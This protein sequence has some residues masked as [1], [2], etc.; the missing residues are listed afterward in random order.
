MLNQNNFN[1]EDDISNSISK[2]KERVIGIETICGR[3]FRTAQIHDEI[4]RREALVVYNR[5]R[6]S[7][8][9]KEFLQGGSHK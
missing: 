6:T 7:P 9:C 1:T 5:V 8:L 3:S 2:L 4:L